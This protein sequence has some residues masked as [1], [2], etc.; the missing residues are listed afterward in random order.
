MGIF[1]KLKK[2]FYKLKKLK[3]SL[4]FDETGRPFIIIKD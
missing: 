4:A 3:M 2:Y 1:S